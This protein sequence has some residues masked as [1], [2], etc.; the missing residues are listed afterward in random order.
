[1]NIRH[2]DHA[3]FSIK[4]ENTLLFQNIWTNNK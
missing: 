4:T 1:M 2:L 3:E